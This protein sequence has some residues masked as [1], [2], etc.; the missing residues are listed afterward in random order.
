MPVRIVADGHVHITN[1]VYWEG[2]DP[3]QPQPFGFD[4]ARAAASGV[5]VVIENVAPYGF[6]NFNYTPRQALRLIETFHRV[7][8]RHADTMGIA[9][10]ADDARR[11]AAD[12]RLAVFLGIESGFDHDGDPDVLRALYRLGLRVVQFATQTCFNAYADAEIDGPPSWHGINDRGRELI[13]TM[14]ELGILIDITHATAP[15][16]QQIIAASRAPVVASHVSM[17]AVS[18]AGM[19]DDTLRALAAGGGLAGI[20]GASASIGARYRD[21][22]AAHPDQAAGAAAPVGAMVT[23]T[24][25]LT[26]AARD[27]GEFGSWLDEQARARHQAA[28]QPW[29]EFPGAAGAVPTADD[30]AAH[31][32]HVIEV[33]GA[34]HAGIGLDLVGGRSCVPQDASGY[35]DLIAALERITTAGNVTKVAGENWMRVLAAAVG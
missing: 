8:E 33:A 13:A 35:P 2:I 25:S 7:A 19:S 29:T 17:A 9:L 20:I 21:W 26:R 16:Q 6:R 28:F 23:F 34:D 32:R 5:N 22:L 14:N 30:W 27:H 12:G 31:V 3:W 18:G 15:A 10:T 11:I 1:R 24:S 4:Y